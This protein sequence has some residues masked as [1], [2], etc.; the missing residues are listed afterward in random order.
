MSLN[1]WKNPTRSNLTRD[2]KQQ[3]L[4]A[5]Y[6]L[7]EEHMSKK[8]PQF[9]A[10]EISKMKE[11]VS[12]QEPEKPREF[13][14]NHP[15]ATPGII[16]PYSYHEYPKMLYQGNS[17]KV[18]DNAQQEKQALDA[19]WSTKPIVKAQIESIPDANDLQEQARVLREENASLKGKTLRG[20]E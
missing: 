7:S 1:E 10:Q 20:K 14:L 11:I 13:D 18:V 3:A 17:T 15:E 4:N 9:S 12:Q 2:Q 19:G 6:G 5:I 8:A 16:P